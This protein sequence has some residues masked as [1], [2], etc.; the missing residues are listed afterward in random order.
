[1][2]YTE[3]TVDVLIIGGGPCS[4]G[5]ITNAIRNGKINDLMS[6]DGIAIIEKE[7]TFGGG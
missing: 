2:K 3:R 5:L 4:L 6:G 7:G 1:M